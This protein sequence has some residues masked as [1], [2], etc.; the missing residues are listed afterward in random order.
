L[1]EIDVISRKIVCEAVKF[2]RYA[3]Q[4]LLHVWLN[5]HFSQSPGV[6]GLGT[7]LG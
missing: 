7:I 1:V 5:G 3:P 6:V 4:Y 2:L